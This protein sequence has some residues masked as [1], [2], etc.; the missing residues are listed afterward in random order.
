[1]SEK[2]LSDSVVYKKM[3]YKD[4]EEQAYKRKQILQH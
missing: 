1:M 3:T 4:D 2:K